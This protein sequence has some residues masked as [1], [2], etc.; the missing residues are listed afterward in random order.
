MPKETI[1]ALVEA[2]KASA[3]PPLGP[4]LGP[5]GVN[6]KKV[7][8]DI[9]TKTAAMKGMKVP[10]KVIIDTVTK[11]YE[12]VVGTPPIASLIK[13]EIG[14]EKGSG[15]AGEVR[16]G[17]ITEAQIKKIA[18]TKFGDDSKA[19]VNQVKGT[20]RSMG[21]TIDAGSL[22]EEEKK[23]AKES[24]KK[25]KPQE[26]KKEESKE[27]GSPKEEG[28]SKEEGKAKEGKKDSKKEKK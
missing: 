27:E 18:K 3:G 5:M 26:A 8:D 19:Y 2:G 21:I 10:V 4:A 6:T 28:K 23:A 15:K 24:S 7:V 14:I 20:C 11:E 1:E 25:E 22:S 13:K 16:A 12:I 17:D 9:N